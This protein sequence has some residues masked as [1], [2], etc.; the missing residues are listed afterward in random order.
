MIGNIFCAV[1]L[2]DE[3]RHGLAAVLSDH[4]A[5]TRIPGRRTKPENWHI[6]LR[7]IGEASDVQIDRLAERLE[8][9]LGISAPGAGT[10]TVDGL[11]AFP[12]PGAA[13]VLYGRI[14][15]RSGLLS[16]LAGI[17]DEAATEVGFEPE[18]RPFV[19]HLTLA[20]IRPAQDVRAV[21]EHLELTPVRVAVTAVT[22]FR[23][24]AVPQGVAYAPL[25]RYDL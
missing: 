21:I 15:D 22:V 17:C 24:T 12:R 10:V 13:T 25:H 11:D 9:L 19:P 4:G 7:F 18:G 1:D 6:T 16:T 20:R 2:T 14:T 8:T 3:E 23:T 5:A